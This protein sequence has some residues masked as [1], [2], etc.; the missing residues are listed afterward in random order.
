MATAS[1]DPLSVLCVELD[2]EMPAIKVQ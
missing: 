1:L 2:V